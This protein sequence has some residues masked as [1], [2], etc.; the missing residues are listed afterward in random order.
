MRRAALGAVALFACALGGCGSG[1]GTVSGEVSYDGKPVKNGYISFLS[2][3]GKGAAVGAPITDGKY[4]AEKV[5]TGKRVVKIEAADKAGPS[6]QTTEELERFSKENKGKIGPS[7][8]I[9]TESVPQDAEGNN[10]KVEVKAGSQ[11]MNFALK[12]P[13]GKR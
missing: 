12:K 11:T 13:A 1:G 5:P 7:G 4:T 6:I 3:D 8:I 2:D 9:S 10:Q